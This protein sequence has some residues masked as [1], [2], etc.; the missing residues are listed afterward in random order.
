M[1]RVVQLANADHWLIGTG[2]RLKPKVKLAAQFNPQIDSLW[3]YV[4]LRANTLGNDIL[5]AMA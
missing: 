2:I 1:S 5:Q 4:H 3:F